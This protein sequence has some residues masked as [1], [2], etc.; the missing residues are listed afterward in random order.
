MKII[1]ESEKIVADMATLREQAK[2]AKS[3]LFFRQAAVQIRSASVANTALANMRA[4][5]LGATNTIIS[6]AKVSGKPL[7]ATTVVAIVKAM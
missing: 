4:T 7:D 3:S 5:S 6:A 2:T 1:F